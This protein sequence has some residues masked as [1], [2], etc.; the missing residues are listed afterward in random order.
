MHIVFW[1]NII[2]PHQAPFMRELANRGLDILV[3]STELMSKDRRRLGWNAPSL[4][5]AQVVLEPDLSQVRQLVIDSPRDA[6]H[7]VAGARGTPLGRQA[8]IACRATGRRMG[9][10]TEAPDARGLAGI[11]R[12]FKYS[13]ERITLGRKFDFILAMGQKGVSWFKGCGYQDCRVFPFAYVTD[14]LAETP[15]VRIGKSFRFLFVGRLVTLKGLD[16]LIEALE[17]VSNS[18]L[19]VIGEGPESNFLRDLAR[20]K[21]LAERVHWVGQVAGPEVH[22]HIAAADVLVL[23][24]RKD[25]WGAVVNESL[26]VGTPVICS[27]ACGAADLIQHPWLGTVFH[28]NDS[29]SL[30]DAMSCWSSQGAITDEQ[31]LRIRD[32]SK[33]IGA[34]VVATYLVD[35]F[36]HVYEHRERPR[37]PWRA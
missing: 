21:G 6:I 11:L 24:S 4:G 5:R 16:L 27:T 25:G 34:P 36:R 10:L 26:M 30:A 14:Q 35:V 8:A 23:P 22:S 19:L 13:Y 28:E 33:C 7:V 29:S 32:W 2:S 1:Q 3:V 12:W 31:R 37:V 15:C 18:E 17:S 9:L 20:R